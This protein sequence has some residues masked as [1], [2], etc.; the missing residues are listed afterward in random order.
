MISR[1]EASRPL[2]YSTTAGGWTSEVPLILWGL[3]LGVSCGQWQLC[4]GPPPPA[5]SFCRMQQLCRASGAVTW[6]DKPMSGESRMTRQRLG[7]GVSSDT[8]LC[9]RSQLS[10]LRGIF[11]PVMSYGFYGFYVWSVYNTMAALLLWSGPSLYQVT[12][13]VGLVKQIWLCFHQLLQMHPAIH[14]CLLQFQSTVGYY[15]LYATADELSGFT[16]QCNY[17]CKLCN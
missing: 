2:L 6:P 11:C 9:W 7:K 16:L 12:H 15:S 4:S 17:V 3:R 1:E 13:T 8:R 5:S 10:G 14:M